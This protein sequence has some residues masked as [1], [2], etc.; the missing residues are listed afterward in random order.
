MTQMDPLDINGASEYNSIPASLT[1]IDAL[2]SLTLMDPMAPYDGANW[3][4]GAI[5][6]NL[7]T[8]Y[9]VHK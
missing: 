2:L 5:V 9:M 7:T 3:K 4:D 6:S 8:R 1:Q